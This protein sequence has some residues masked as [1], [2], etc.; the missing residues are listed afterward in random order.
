MNRTEKLSKL[1]KLGKDR[2][3]KC[4]PNFL[5]IKDILNGEY[6]SDF[7]SP[8]TKSAG[9]VDSQIMVLLQDWASSEG[10]SKQCNEE[11]MKFGYNPSLRTNKNFFTLLK[12]TF[13]KNISD[14]FVT[15][16]FPYIKIGNMSK[17]I[18]QQYLDQGFEEF[19]LPQIRIINPKLVICCGKKVFV[20]VAKYFSDPQR[21]NPK[22]HD[23]FTID[24]VTYYYQRHP[25]PL[26]INKHGKIRKA[27]S[28]WQVM[29]NSM[30]NNG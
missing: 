9:N 6:E 29:K 21:H 13:N 16:I 3:S 28:D 23:N 2:Q 4:Y 26:A 19:C 10:F 11:I 14:I 5:N 24:A 22:I 27:L 8:Y 12:Q 7:V 20:T 15:N 17:N 18:P 25:S 1:K 30:P